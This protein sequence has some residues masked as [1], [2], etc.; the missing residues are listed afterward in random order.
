M[1]LQFVDPENAGRE[2]FGDLKDFLDALFGF[3]YVFVVDGSGIELH[4]GKL[5]FAGDGASAHALA[6]PLDAEDDHAAWGIEP[7][8][9][10]RVFPRTPALGEKPFEVLNSTYAGQRLRDLDEVEHLGRQRACST[11]QN[12]EAAN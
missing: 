6:A 4:Q 3:A 1:I 12:K 2:S 9:A 7:K 5:P 10:S 11:F 8:G